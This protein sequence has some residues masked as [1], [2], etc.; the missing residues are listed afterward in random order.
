M[1]VEIF[2]CEFCGFWV[3]FGVATVV[4][5]KAWYELAIKAI[6]ESAANVSGNLRIVNVKLCELWL[7]SS[8][9]LEG[10]CNVVERTMNLEAIRAVTSCTSVRLSAIN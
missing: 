6:K 9:R 4:S 1:V 3:R 7:R 5:R 8:Y 10:S 2:R